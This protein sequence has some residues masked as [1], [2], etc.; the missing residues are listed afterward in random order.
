MS[1]RLSKL[2][3]SSRAASRP[4]PAEQCQKPPEKYRCTLKNRTYN[5]WQRT[6]RVRRDVSHDANLAVT[7][8]CPHFRR[9]YC[10]LRGRLQLERSRRQSET[11]I[12]LLLYTSNSPEDCT[13]SAS[14]VMITSIQRSVRHAYA[15]DPLRTRRANSLQV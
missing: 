4:D 9:C 5:A 6:T 15:I 11:L 8:V 7:T 1:N 13:H 2:Y 10:L 14:H 3:A 12:S